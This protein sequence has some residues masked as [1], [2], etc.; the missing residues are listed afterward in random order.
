MLHDPFSQ[1][2]HTLTAVRLEDRFVGYLIIGSVLCLPVTSLPNHCV[3]K[4]AS[5]GTKCSTGVLL[6]GMKL[7]TSEEDLQELNR[8]YQHGH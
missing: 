7:S 4:T 5:S 2:Q 8:M 1:E 6:N 3:L